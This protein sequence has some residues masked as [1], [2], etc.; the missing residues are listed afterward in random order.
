[1][2]WQDRNRDR[3]TN[4]VTPE[5]DEECFHSVAYVRDRLS[6]DPETGVFMF[7]FNPDMPNC[8]NNRFAGKEA[9]C[10]RRGYRVIRLG[11]KLYPAH[12]LAWAIYYG[13]WPT[14]TIDHINGIR[15]D[16]RIANLRD[17]PHKTNMRNMRMKSCNTSGVTGVTWKTHDSKW[18]AQIKVDGRNIYLGRYTDFDEAVRARSL[19]ERRYGFHEN[20]GLPVSHDD[21]D[22]EGFQRWNAANTARMYLANMPAERRAMLEAEWADEPKGPRSCA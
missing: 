13:E 16:N 18:V 14:H 20:H 7:R 19:A 4:L 5:D 8:Y 1:M 15:S 6:Y 12:R 3:L 21:E 22:G 11:Y 17:V 9:G 2:S 10:F